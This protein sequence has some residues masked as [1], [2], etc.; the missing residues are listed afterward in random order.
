MA[1]H[2]VHNYM[3]FGLSSLLAVEDFCWWLRQLCLTSFVLF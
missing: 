3:G 2:F 1:S